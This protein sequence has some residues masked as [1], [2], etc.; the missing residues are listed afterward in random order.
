MKRR[1]IIAFVRQTRHKISTS[2]NTCDPCDSNYIAAGSHFYLMS[3][4]YT[5]IMKFDY[6]LDRALYF[7]T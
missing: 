2:N 3:F 4:D 1:N 6:L 7:K 5:D